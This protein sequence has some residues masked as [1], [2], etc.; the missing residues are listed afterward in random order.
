MGNL[1]QLFYRYGGLVT[2]VVVQSFCLFRIV[3]V[4]TDK[5]L[6]F[7][8][9]WGLLT[10]SVME[11]QQRMA[12]YIGLQQRV[13]S[14]A[15]HNAELKQK[16]A[17]I[18]AIQLPQKD[19]FTIVWFDSL[20]QND[21]MRRKYIRPSYTYNSAR[22]IGNTIQNTNNWIVINRG[23]SD[24]IKPDMGVASDKGIVGITRHVDPNTSAVMSLLHQKTMISAKLI[25][26]PGQTTI[27]S[28]YWQGGDPSVM[29]LRD[30][31]KHFASRIKP[32]IKVVTSGLS[33][34]FPADLSIGVV[35]DEPTQNAESPYYLDI[36]VKLSQDMSALGDVYI[37][38]NILKTETDSL[39]IKI[40]DGQ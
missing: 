29:T 8:Y 16:I 21:T 11:R 6:I 10:G 31:P 14:L 27:G 3:R 1:L 32:G 13:D 24:G 22:V 36:K 23:A 26:A 39:L 18:E 20:M 38:N 2:F 40:K 28:L 7:N 15:K 5:S 4:S 35:V 25:F 9:S 12:D 19:T 17:N 37:I 30:I 34:K 33:D